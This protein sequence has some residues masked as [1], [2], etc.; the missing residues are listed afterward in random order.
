[1]ARDFPGSNDYLSDTSVGSLVVDDTAGTLSHWAKFDDTSSQLAPFG[2]SN[3]ATSNKDEYLAWRFSLGR[4]RI[5]VRNN[6]T[7]AYTI[8]SDN[9]IVDNTNWQQWSY[10]Q[11]GSSG[12]MVLFVDG[13]DENLNLIAGTDGGEWFAHA[14]DADAV[15]IGGLLRNV[16]VVDMDGLIGEVASWT[17]VLSDNERQA[18][19]RGVSAFPIRNDTQNFYAPVMGNE[20][21]E[22]DMKNNIQFALTGTANKAPHPPTEIPVENYV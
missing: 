14:G 11:T 8:S 13:T 4:V 20:D 19:A 6:D 12:G 3:Q 22:M 1:M 2:I 21:P 17:E 15:V 5:L 10:S 16:L 9:N 7:D 18:L